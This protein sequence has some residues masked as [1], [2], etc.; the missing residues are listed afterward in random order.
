M[1]SGSSDGGILPGALNE[2]SMMRN[3]LQT[4]DRRVAEWDKWLVPLVAAVLLASLVIY[5]QQRDPL[6]FGPY[7]GKNYERLGWAAARASHL[8]AEDNFAHAYWSPGWV[9][10]IGVVYKIVGRNPLAI[11]LLLAVCA[12]GSGLMVYFWL[13]R[14]H[15]PASAC[16]LA[17][18][19]TVTNTLVFR[20]VAFCHYEVALGFGL[21]VFS[22]LVFEGNR[23][24]DDGDGKGRALL[25]LAGLLLGYLCL[26]AS[27]VAAL[28]FVLPVLLAW[29]GRKRAAVRTWMVAATCLLVLGA[30]TTRNLVIFGEF[31][32]LTSNGGINL[33]IANN[34]DATNGYMNVD[35]GGRPLHDGAH[36]TM[37][38]VDYILENPGTTA[39]RMMKKAAMFFNPHYGDQFPLMILFAV[40]LVR[41]IR[42]PGI[43]KDSEGLWFVAMP[44]VIMA[45][46]TVFHAEFRYI[47]PV[48]PALA[49]V[50]GHA[51]TG[52][53]TPLDL[54]DHHE[55]DSSLFRSKRPSCGPRAVA[56]GP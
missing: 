54:N 13:R 50:G 21:M 2:E 6:D 37:L 4:V 28:L 41:F 17:M 55:G 27:K 9:A 51:F 18:V 32:P 33:Y 38:A 49:W 11:R 1:T 3:F 36:F 43:R 31:I 7:D 44:F 25:L 35:T 56:G 29:S 14:R 26:F 30:W 53:K 5:L 45:V 8:F 15:L 23:R 24:V 22:W 42:M 16:L 48:W 19:L 47:L 20:F 52:W 12:V 10:T 40:A 46:H 39:L 34:P